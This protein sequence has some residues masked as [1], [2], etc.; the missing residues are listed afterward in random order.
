MFYG[1]GEASSVE[2]LEN[3]GK[4]QEWWTLIEEGKK[5][6]RRKLVEASPCR[7]AWEKKKKNWKSFASHS[8]KNSCGLNEALNKS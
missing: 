7:Q 1:F 3:G 6:C 4:S 8:V 5:K 2:A